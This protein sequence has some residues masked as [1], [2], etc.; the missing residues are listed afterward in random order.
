MTDRLEQ[1]LP[2]RGPGTLGAGRLQALAV[3]ALLAAA[4][5]CVA[6][7]AHAVQLAIQS[8][9]EYVRGLGAWG[10]VL[11]VI[12]YVVA[13]VLLIPGSWLTLAAGYAFH[14]AWGT[15]AVCVGSLLGASA[16]FWL[17]RTVAR[18]WVA[19]KT[20]A[21]PRLQAIDHAVA[22][23]AFK[24]ILLARLSPVIPFS[25]LNYFLGITR[26]SFRDFI[27]ASLIGMF[28]GTLMYVYLGSAL[29]SL[30]EPAAADSKTSWLRGLLFGAGLLA[31]IAVTLVVTRIARNALRTA[32]QRE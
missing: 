7:N 27:M 13:C 30:T 25:L 16:A 11:F 22:E 14:L 31:T 6:F 18:N 29:R 19:R 20:A 1:Q 17:G 28:P 12:A 26:V 3:L 32:A 2:A 21:D 15:L 8:F 23:Q 9:V 5:L 10:L 24:I 4:G